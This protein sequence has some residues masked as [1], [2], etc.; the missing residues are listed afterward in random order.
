[1]ADAVKILVAHSD[2]EVRQTLV[3]AIEGL[4]YQ[5]QGQVGT[6]AGLLEQCQRKRPELIMSGV[7][8]P[9]GD[10][11]SA[12]IE[13]SKE[14]PIPAIV[15]TQSESLQDVERAIQDHVMAYLLEP[16][17]PEHIQPT[18]YLVLRR[19]EQFEALHE[20]VQDLRQALADRKIIERAKGILMSQSKLDEGDAF[21]RLQKLAS[22]KRRKLV[23]IANAIITAQEAMSD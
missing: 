10:A 23:D 22:E 7:D 6:H 12:L 19:F 16:I 11:L 4:D 13:I 5:V 21:R 18:I 2:A 9:D 20:E 17:E 15:V 8:L 1:M 3:E 14:E